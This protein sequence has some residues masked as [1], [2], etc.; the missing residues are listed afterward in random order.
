MIELKR[1][2]ETLADQWHNY[3]GGGTTTNKERAAQLRRIIA[4][5]DF[6]EQEVVDTAAAQKLMDEFCSAPIACK[7]S[8]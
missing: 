3:I 1:E 8:E 5:Y 6:E 7:L 4:K 2:L